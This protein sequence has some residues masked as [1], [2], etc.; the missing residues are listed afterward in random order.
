MR[1]AV[2]RTPDP[3]RSRFAAVV[4]GVIA[5]ALL[6]LPALASAAYPPAKNGRIAFR[7]NRAGVDDTD[8]FL[9]QPNGSNPVELKT[10]LT[11][12]AGFYFEG[13]PVFSPTGGRI[14]F[15]A[16]VGAVN[17]YYDVYT[18]SNTGSGLLD[19]TSVNS[20][21]DASPSYSPDGKRI[22]YAAYS[23]GT[24]ADIFV[25]DADGSNKVDLTPGASSEFSPDWSPDGERI[26]F[27]R[28]VSRTGTDNFDVMAINADGTWTVDLTPV[29]PSLDSNPHFSPDGKRIVFTST[30]T[31][32]NDIWV[33]NADG[34]G[35]VNLTPN[36][37]TLDEDAVFSPDGTK[38]AYN[39]VVLAPA[40]ADDDIV[41]MNADGSGTVSLTDP[42][43]SFVNDDP[44]W[45]YVYQ[46]FSKAPTTVGDASGGKIVGS[47]RAD[48]IVGN[49]GKDRIFGKGGDDRI[50]G[51]SGKDRIF[52]GPGDDL[53][54]GQGGND[55]LIG[56]KGDNR[57]RG[58]KGKD[59]QKG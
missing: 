27:T 58:G 55:L 52:G 25:M 22:A 10:G 51:G 49:A 21:D 29:T 53:L 28:N 42:F 17:H 56:G 14:A 23:S 1:I 5:A 59:R 6:S 18:I 13:G 32:S 45:E 33:M 57:L 48:V 54:A 35:P 26:V 34:S 20:F 38:I 19:L 8:L 44:D 36:S 50:C 37:P 39:R 15:N 47:K 46:C 11:D 3:P 41:V 4:V 31:G 40:P 7:S 12:P 43:S 30:R 2:S 9:M 24:G 16:G